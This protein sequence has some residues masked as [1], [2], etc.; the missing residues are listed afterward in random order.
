M[1]TREEN[2]L[3]MRRWRRRKR[4]KNASELF[5]RARTAYYEKIVRIWTEK[6]VMAGIRFRNR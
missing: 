3:H 2:K 4:K 1:R 6:M 5:D